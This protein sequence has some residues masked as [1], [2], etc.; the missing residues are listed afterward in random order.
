[1][2]RRARGEL[3][4]RNPRLGA[5]APELFGKFSKYE[6]TGLRDDKYQLPLTIQLLDQYLKRNLDIFP[7]RIEDKCCFW[8]IRIL[9]SDMV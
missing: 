4:A 3:P 5:C 7:S 1:M 9:L 2:W 6:A 8:R